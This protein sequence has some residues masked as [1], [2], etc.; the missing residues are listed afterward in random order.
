MTKLILSIKR[1]F[2]TTLILIKEQINEP[3][4][5]IWILASPVAMFYFYANQPHQDMSVIAYVDYA[6][7]FYGYVAV[8]VAMFGFSYY[9][10]GRRESGF[11]RSFIYHKRAQTYYLA[12]HF[13]AYSIIALIYSISFYLITKPF[14]ETY[15]PQELIA[16]SGRFY[17]AFVSLTGSAAL[18]SLI[19][20][21]FSSA[22]MLFSIISLSMIAL[23]GARRQSDSLDFLDNLNPLA[24]VEHIIIK[25]P[26]LLWLS[27]ILLLNFIALAIT[28]VN[29]RVNPVWNRY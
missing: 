11:V 23:S 10:I 21:K 26:S 18:L 6:S 1:I 9:L 8:T 15:D 4:A 12:S 16:L 7:W 19:P 17:I 3:F 5:F 28:T 14:F 13:L 27:I 25:P 22:G 29:L 24:Y 20:M 2:I